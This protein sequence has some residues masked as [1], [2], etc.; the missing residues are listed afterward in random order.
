M[1]SRECRHCDYYNT[2]DTS[3]SGLGTVHSSEPYCDY[4]GAPIHDIEQCD[5]ADSA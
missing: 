1:T 5:R 4:W 3:E 2:D